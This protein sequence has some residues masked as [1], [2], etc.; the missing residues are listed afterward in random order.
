MG[1]SLFR[2]DVG[3]AVLLSVPFQ[4][5]FVPRDSTPFTSSNSP[6]HS[7]DFVPTD[8]AIA[9]GAI[10]IALIAGTSA[11]AVL[12]TGVGVGAVL[13]VRRRSGPRDA[14]ADLA[15]VSPDADV[16]DSGLHE[17]LITSPDSVTIEDAR[18]D[19]IFTFSTDST[20]N[21]SLA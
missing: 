5:T 3:S 8:A 20:L 7:S 15:D 17:T 19:A 21:Y 13:L 2:P 16:L 11:G 14:N 1:S 18:P 10:P 6:L 12:L 4:P 9:S